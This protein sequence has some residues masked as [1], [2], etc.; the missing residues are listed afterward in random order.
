MYEIHERI[1]FVFYLLRASY[2]PI[3]GYNARNE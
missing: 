1:I 2:N 3:N